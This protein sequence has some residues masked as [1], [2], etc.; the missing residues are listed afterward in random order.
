MTSNPDPVERAARI[1]RMFGQIA[2][3][4]DLANRLMTAGLDLTWRH[5]AVRGLHLSPGARVLDL[6]CGTGDLAREVMRQAPKVQVVAADFTLPMLLLGRQRAF[7]HPPAWCAADA[8]ALP[9][10]TGSFDALVCAFLL[11]N[12]ADLPQALREIARVLRPGGQIAILETTHPIP[13]PLR[14]LRDVLMFKMIPWIGGMLTGKREAY[15]Y[16][17]HSSATFLS[18]PEL[19]AALETVGFSEVHFVYKMMGTIAI[20]WGHT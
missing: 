8:L 12:V 10:A 14:P 5:E 15:E 13:H 9:F 17:A 18:A 2:P 4:Y 6:G 20:H 16:L 3:R 1:R 19:A 11:R 7:P